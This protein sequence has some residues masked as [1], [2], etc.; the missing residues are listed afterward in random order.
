MTKFKIGDRIRV[1]EESGQDPPG[2]VNEH[3]IKCI[4]KEYAYVFDTSECRGSLCD[5]G[6][7]HSWCLREEQMELIEEVKPI[8]I[9]KKLGN[10]MKK[11]LDSDTQVLVEAG[12]I[13]GDLEI[14]SDGS[15]VLQ[16]I[17]F[18]T[19][20]KTFVELAKKKVE[21]EKKESEK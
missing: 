9:M 19:F 3:V 13:N 10:M 2:I 12:Y 6:K 1:K 5:C 8:K 20:K 21:E 14:T 15:K 16:E 7:K 11:L 4:D 17:S 18:D